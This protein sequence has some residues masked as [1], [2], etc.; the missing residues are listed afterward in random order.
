[1]NQI[2]NYFLLIV[3]LFIC[4]QSVVV[5]Q[6]VFISPVQVLKKNLDKRN[7]FPGIL[8]D[9]MFPSPNMNSFCLS[10][11]DSINFSDTSP[12]STQHLFLQNRPTASMSDLFLFRRSDQFRYDIHD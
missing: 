3:F 2:L 7:F 8:P 4:S 6:Y 5:I 1:M 9:T 12:F 10:D 11:V